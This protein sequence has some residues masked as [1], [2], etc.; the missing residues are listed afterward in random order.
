M[1]LA[2]EAKRIEYA[3]LPDSSKGRGGRQDVNAPE[4]S[5]VSLPNKKEA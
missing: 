4:G 5:V 2:L 1:S 3:T